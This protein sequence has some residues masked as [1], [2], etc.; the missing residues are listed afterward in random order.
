MTWE[1]RERYLNPYKVEWVAEEELESRLNDG[2]QNNWT[3]VSVHVRGDDFV[4]IWD[5]IGDDDVDE[6]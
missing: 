2:H 4:I 3:L 1:E 6:E 5:K